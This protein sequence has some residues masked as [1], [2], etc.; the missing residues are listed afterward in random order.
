MIRFA[1][2][3][4]AL[5]FITS[6]A[7]LALGHP[8]MEI[9]SPNAETDGW[10]G[11]AGADG[12]DVDGDGVNDIVVGPPQEDPPPSYFYM[13]RAYLFSGATGMPIRTLFSP[14]ET[15][16]GWSNNFGWSVCGVGDINGSGYDDVL[17]G[18]P[19]EDIWD[20]IDWLIDAGRAYVFEGSIGA[21]VL[22]MEHWG[23]DP[24]FVGLFGYAVNVLDDVNDDGI[25]DKIVGS[26]NVAEA[27]GA[28]FIMDGATGAE[29]EWLNPPDVQIPAYVGAA[30][31][32]VD[33]IDRDGVGD[34]LVGAPWMTPAGSSVWRPEYIMGGR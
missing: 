21:V 15:I 23:P 12:G 6:V 3:V 24:F 27:G 31:A 33:D 13:G 1:I 34:A 16:E 20:D 9:L 30:V 5:L 22:Q 28:A 19:F 25:P 4:P 11:Y 26:V 2:A 8:R 32:G 17:V 10:F 7:H 29:L 18:S 14:H